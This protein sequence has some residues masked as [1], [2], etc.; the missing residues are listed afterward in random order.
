MHPIQR[1]IYRRMTPAQKWQR[2]VDLD[3]TARALR[4]AGIRL[5]HPDWTDE[6]VEREVV[7]SILH[8][9]G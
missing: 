3:Q 1:E 6:Q 7:R 8:A 4:R 5:L 9:R 2:L